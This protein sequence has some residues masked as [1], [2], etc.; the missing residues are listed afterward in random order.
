MTTRPAR[1]PAERGPQGLYVDRR[2]RLRVASRKENSIFK[3]VDD[4]YRTC[5]VVGG[6]F[7][8]SE[9]L[10]VRQHAPGNHTFDSTYLAVA[11][12]VAFLR[13][14]GRANLEFD[15]NE[16]VDTYNHEGGMHLLNSV[17]GVLRDCGINEDLISALE[18]EARQLFIVEP[19]LA[20]QGH[21]NTHLTAAVSGLT[22]ELKASRETKEAAMRVKLAAED[23]RRKKKS[24]PSLAKVGV[25]TFL[26]ATVGPGD[27]DNEASD[28]DMG[29]EGEGADGGR[30][31]F[32]TP[33][34]HSGSASSR[35]RRS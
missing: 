8:M 3:K 32:I 35:K 23:V 11:N 7:F 27:E 6:A 2:E 9:T 30:L 16:V 26:A 25:A 19:T 5:G 20:L 33:D 28:N 10:H 21:L 1:K 13:Q 34:K 15:V 4:L 31:P 14:F 12:L 18:Q 24:E 17:C 29:E 22:Q